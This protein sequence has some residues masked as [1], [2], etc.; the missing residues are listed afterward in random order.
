M[1]LP[2]L[3]ITFL[4]STYPFV[5]IA[6]QESPDP[7]P[8][9]TARLAELE[10]QNQELRRELDA[11]RAST[12]DA[13]MLRAANVELERNN[14]A[15]RQQLEALGQELAAAQSSARH[16]LFI[17]GATAV[18]AGILAALLVAWLWPRKKRS[19]WA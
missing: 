1:R 10:R 19:E 6:Q 18:V 17:N 16:R 7:E 14:R 5:A 13:G 11:L 12:G 3:F 8:M 9:M 4:L 2:G 15:L